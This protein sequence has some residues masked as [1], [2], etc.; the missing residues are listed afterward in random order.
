MVVKTPCPFNGGENNSTVAIDRGIRP[1]L[2]V[3]LNN[4]IRINPR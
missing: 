4:L 3:L 2:R 1:R